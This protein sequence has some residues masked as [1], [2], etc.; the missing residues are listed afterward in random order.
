MLQMLNNVRMPEGN[1]SLEKSVAWPS[2]NRYFHEGVLGYCNSINTRPEQ[3]GVVFIDF[4]LSNLLFFLEQDW[5]VCSLYS[6]IVLIT[7]SYLLPLANYYKETFHQIDSVIHV[8]GASEDFFIQIE[9]VISGLRVSSVSQ[10]CFSSREICLLRT[11][12]RGVS[13]RGI[14]DRLQLSPKTVYSM[15]QSL[16]EKMGL[17]KMNH[18]FM[19]TVKEVR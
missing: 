8:T 18:I 3:L 14:A 13:V 17:T 4:Q 16:L 11:L 1:D 19:Y 2:T 12:A 10:E 9:Y 7:D 15:R 5:L 6:R